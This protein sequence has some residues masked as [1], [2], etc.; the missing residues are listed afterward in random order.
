M[1]LNTAGTHYI[2]NGRKWWATGAADPRCQLFFV[3]G[4][5][6]PSAPKHRQQSVLIVP[7]QTLGIT[8]VRPLHTFG[9]DDAPYGHC[10][11][12]FEDVMVPVENIML[13][14][15]RGFEVVQGRLGPGR[16]HHC[17]RTVGLAY[18]AYELMLSRLSDSSRVTFGLPLFKHELLL[19]YVAESRISIAKMRLLVHQAAQQLDRIGNKLSRRE[20]ALAKIVVPREAAKV[21]DWAIQIMGAKGVSQ[22][23]RLSFPCVP[24]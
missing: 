16:L 23:R 12:F 19:S 24:L 8:I 1:T 15:G 2:I 7:R 17:A 14:E 10:E 5:T 13:G 21:I 9:Y 18:R 22:V 20:I 11:V 4:K 3:M 6:S